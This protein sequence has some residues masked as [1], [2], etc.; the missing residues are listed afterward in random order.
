VVAT[1]VA[2]V[3]VWYLV[4]RLRASRYRAWA[5]AVFVLVLVQLDLGLLLGVTRLQGRSPVS[6]PIPVA[7][8]DAIGGLPADAKLAYACQSLEEIS[9]IN[10]KLLGIDAHTDRRI[11]PMCFEADVNGPLLGAPV[12]AEA[13]DPGF[14][15]APQASLY[16]SASARPSSEAVM[17]FLKTHGI[18]YIYADDAHPNALAPAATVVAS[19]GGYELLRLP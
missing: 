9:F 11:V 12:S 17:A 13:A 15:S 16:P 6:E 2:A 18:E 5:V 4:G 10:S 7:V 8:L 3:A 14:A 1:P 19:S